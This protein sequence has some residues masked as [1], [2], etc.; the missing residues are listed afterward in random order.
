DQHVE[1]TAAEGGHHRFLLSGRQLTVEKAETESAQ[2]LGAEPL[3]LLGRRAGLD[4]LGL[5]DERA[6]HVGLMA[7]LDL[8]ADLLPRVGHLERAA[9]PGR[10]DRR[11][12]RGSSSSTVASRSP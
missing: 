8:A 1:L 6:H 3:E 11:P 7:P 9:G 10:S 5:L 4:A 2:H 12:A